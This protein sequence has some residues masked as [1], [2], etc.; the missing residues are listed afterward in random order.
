[1]IYNKELPNTGI[2]PD[3]K[4][5]SSTFNDFLLS[6]NSKIFN[7]VMIVLVTFLLFFVGIIAY[8]NTKNVRN[9]KYN[10][11]IIKHY[12]KDLKSLN[13]CE[14]EK[15]Y[16]LVDYY[17]ASSFNTASLGGNHFDYVSL[18]AV[19]NT[20]LQGA[21]YIQLNI[22]SKNVD[23]NDVK[24]EPVVGTS[25]KGNNYITSINT[26]S[27]LDVFEIINAYSFKVLNKDGNSFKD[28]NYPLIIEFKINTHNKFVINKI[29]KYAKKIFD[30]RLLNPEKYKT[31]PLQFEY[32]CNLRNKIVCLTKDTNNLKDTDSDN[33]FIKKNIL[34]KTIN[35]N[36]I[37]MS[38]LTPREF[39][40]YILS[41][42]RI[43][44]NNLYKNNDDIHKVISN[45]INGAL[46]NENTFDFNSENGEIL[47]RGD[48]D[49]KLI[50]FNAIGLTTIEPDN[51]TMI[52]KAYDY[53]LPM[54]IGCQLMLMPY[55]DVNNIYFRYY[56]EFF[57]E[58]SFVLK[59]SNVRLPDNLYLSDNN[60]ENTNEIE[61]DLDHFLNIYNEFKK[62]QHPVNY[63]PKYNFYKNLLI[64]LH[65]I[66]TP[67]YRYLT[68]NKDMTINFKPKNDKIW[69]LLKA[70][71]YDEFNAYYIL[72]PL[73][74]NFCLTVKDNFKK[75]SNDPFY[76]SPIENEMVNINQLF[77]I[78][79]GL[80]IENTVSRDDERFISIRSLV[81][82]NTEKPQYLTFSRN[83]LILSSLGDKPNKLITFN[84]S[85]KLVKF[86]CVIHN[87]LF[88][89]IF[90][91]DNGYGVI[92]DKDPTELIIEYNDQFSSNKINISI[93]VKSTNKYLN[94]IDNKLAP[95]DKKSFFTLIIIDDNN[96]MIKSNN[97]TLVVNNKNKMLEFVQV[98]GS[99]YSS[100]KI[101]N[102][103]NI[104]V[105]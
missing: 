9:E 51:S 63:N 102:I 48:V 93:L 14:S 15:N 32:L 67:N 82:I 84:S 2:L 10:D 53:R 68:L 22:F 52:P 16:R 80:E 96:F 75:N 43:N 1:M 23:I 105:L 49:G 42:S 86:V 81:S 3:I 33:L 31:Y 36:Q 18:D 91:Y 69:F 87:L 37:M 27:L 47:R 4:K 72:N 26:L 19:K 20:L 41:L 40:T 83:E 29:V 77:L 95:T 5:K 94:N 99:E 79:N 24:D 65:E 55:H 28:I 101:F 30:M 38:T 88:G 61:D 21:R 104:K 90:I 100:E 78:E 39:E 74:L 46:N 89:N 17:I 98:T 44:L 97:L 92:S 35:I 59:Q 12:A 70:I 58:S 54:A 50:Y 57:K 103:K 34:M 11:T 64:N 13:K 6:F 76:F 60:K 66:T 62:Q 25:F 7:I 45:L 73:K 71:T 56:K 85:Y 8:N